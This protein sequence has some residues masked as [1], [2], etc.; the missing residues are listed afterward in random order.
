MWRCAVWRAWISVK[1]PSGGGAVG[2]D[3]GYHG[4]IV[5][6]GSSNAGCLHSSA[7]Q[8]T[9]S[10]MREPGERFMRERHMQTLS[11]GAGESRRGWRVD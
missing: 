3:W 2:G 7:T 9:A 10:E 5:H 6:P 8:N 11:G 1:K 4:V